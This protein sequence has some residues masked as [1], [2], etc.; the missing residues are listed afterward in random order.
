MSYCHIPKYLHSIS[1]C[2][3]MSMIFGQDVL[4]YTLKVFRMYLTDWC[5]KEAPNWTNQRK[6]FCFSHLPK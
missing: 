3:K 1:P 4:R 6:L 2:F 5:H